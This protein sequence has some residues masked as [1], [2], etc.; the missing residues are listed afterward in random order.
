[1]ILD[2]I[3]RRHSDSPP[4]RA[5]QGAGTRVLSLF[6]NATLA[7]YAH[8]E[9]LEPLECESLIGLHRTMAD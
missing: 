7:L 9:G 5:G 1:V 3:D 2:A 6:F 4:S 8:D